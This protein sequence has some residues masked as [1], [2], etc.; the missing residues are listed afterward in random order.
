M[1]LE[2]LLLQYSMEWLTKEVGKDLVGD[3]G[4]VGE[5]CGAV[6]GGGRFEGIPLQIQVLQYRQS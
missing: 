3:G 6:G 1:L 2:T 4:E 5:Y